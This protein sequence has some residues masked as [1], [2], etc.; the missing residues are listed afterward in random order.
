M[1]AFCLLNTITEY[2]MNIEFE[3]SSLFEGRFI[4]TTVIDIISHLGVKH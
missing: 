3:F 2:L 1:K 4:I